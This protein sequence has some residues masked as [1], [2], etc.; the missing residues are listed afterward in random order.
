MLSEAILDGLVWSPPPAFTAIGLFLVQLPH[1]H[2]EPSSELTVLCAH[3]PTKKNLDKCKQGM[4]QPGHVDRSA[5]STAPS[6]C[7]PSSEGCGKGFK[8]YGAKR[9][10]SL[11]AVW[12]LGW[13]SWKN[14]KIRGS[15]FTKVISAKECQIR[16]G[17]FPYRAA[18]LLNAFQT[19]IA[20]FKF[21]RA[22]ILN[23]PFSNLILSCTNHWKI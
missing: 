3:F 22:V 17:K 2:H 20:S 11:Q 14:K 21:N 1:T 7:T 23:M 10:G 19:C 15:S 18:D 8:L 16:W 6:S 5:A 4:L 12:V 13:E 9:R